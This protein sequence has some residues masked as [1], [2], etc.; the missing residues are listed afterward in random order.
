MQ[1]VN[2][3]GART[4]TGSP[5]QPAQDKVALQAATLLERGMQHHRQG[6][7]SQAEALY[8][9]VLELW[10]NQPDALHLLGLIAHQNG[11]YDIA[12]RLIDL[13]IAANPSFPVY[14][15]NR[16]N[17]LK[18]LGRWDKALESFDRA[19]ALKPD[20]TDAYFN[21]GALLH[22]TRDFQAALASYDRLLELDPRRFDAYNNRGNTLRMLERYDEALA[23]F[24]KAIGI[25]PERADAYNNCGN[26]L[27]DKKDFTGALNWYDKALQLDPALEQAW[28]NRGLA[29][30]ELKDY[31]K[32]IES[33][34]RA[35]LINPQLPDTFNNWGIA[36]VE[37]KQFQAALDCYQKAITLNPNLPQVWWNRGEARMQLKQYKEA[38]EDLDR[39]YDLQPDYKFLDGMRVH[40]KRTLC[41]WQ[42]A[43][44]DRDR[45]ESAVRRKERAI[46]PFCLLAVSG[47]PELQRTAAETFLRDNINASYSQPA[48]TVR[49][50]Q[51]KLRVAYVS[52][53]F[54]DH[55]VSYLIAELLERHDRSRFEIV[56]VSIGPQSRSEMRQRITHGVDRFVDVHT[57]ADREI[58]RLCREMNVHIAMDLNGLSFGCRPQ[59]F[60]QRIA[61]VQITWLGHPGT[62]GADFIDYLI[63]DETVI[64]EDYREHYSEKIVYLPDSFQCNDSTQPIAS[65]EFCRR[66]L[67]LPDTGVVYSCFN[68]LAKITPQIFDVWM[69]ILGQV[70][71]S[72]LWLTASDPEARK[73]LKAEAEKRGIS[74]ARL[75]FAESLPLSEHLRR[76]QWADL[77]LDT[78][79]FNSGATA[80]SA[81]WA[82]LP[83]LTCLGEAFAGRMA[84]SL[85][86]AVGLGDLVTHDLKEY[87][88]RAVGIG[89]DERK[90]RELK[91]RLWTNRTCAPLYDT[92]SF[93]RHLESAY[94]AMYER[95]EAGMRPDHLRVLR[96]TGTETVLG[97]GS[98]SRSTEIP[99]QRSENSTL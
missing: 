20:Y 48:F 78:L 91:T 39:A 46:S 71:G 17:S 82:G 81:L 19:I 38:L 23:S 65:R 3:S 72:V 56:A 95:F 29:S 97:T 67:G 18:S 90:I 70:E 34:R 60:A 9:Q 96:S 25:C 6:E 66:D 22:Q 51:E 24:E 84:A 35:A 7:L 50:S 44:L 42:D 33:F 47:N 98:Q 13:A 45:I 53:D 63:A 14:Y 1:I 77:F 16:G 57:Q 12:V 86:R 2:R 85:L 10:P 75:V 28:S 5:P 21:R 52:A 36:L 92:A 31:A 59:V 37:L 58:V 76:Q 43:E 74:S 64:P 26:V 30:L 93:T 11:R 73:N 69:R 88:A 80:S 4:P 55:P 40:L 27:L 61:P 83:I 54:H 62:T 68:N 89:R 41:V 87:E 15:N 79:P 32:A 94:E 49:A 99:H 8:K